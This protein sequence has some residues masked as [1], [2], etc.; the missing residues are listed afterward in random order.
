MTALTHRSKPRRTGSGGVAAR[1]AV[2]RWAWRMFRRE[3]RRQILVIALLTVAVAAAI[4]SVTIAYNAAAADDAEFGS[5]NHLIRFDGTDPRKLEAGLAAARDRFGT[6]DVIGHRSLDVPGSVDPVEF[7]SQAPR[8]PYGDARLALRRGSYPDRPG[9]VAV[10]DGVATLLGLEIG[11][12]LALDGRRRRVVGVVE[13]PRDLSDEFA[14]VTP[15]SARAPDEVTVLVE[16]SAGSVDAFARSLDGG[17]GSA[18]AG[19]EERPNDQAASALAMFSVATVFLLLASLV[20]S[21]GF[22]VIA[23]R[24]LRQLG[25]LTAIGATEKHLRLVLLTGGAVVG[26]IGAL[27]G[28]IVGLALWLAIVGTLEPAVGHRIDPLS[29]PWALLAATVLVAVLGATA[30]AWWPGRV[31]ARI[32]VTLALSARP[33]R[34]RPTHH[35]TV[36]AAVLIAAG[37]ASLALSGRDSEPLIVAGILA[38]ILGTLLLAPVAIRLFARAAGHAPLAARL[39]LR[40]LSRYQARSGAALA[41]ITLALGIA[42]A[43]VIV[44]EAEERKSASEPPNLSNRQIRVYAGG[45]AGPEVVPIRTPAELERMAGDVRRLAAGFDDAAVVPLHNAYQPGE[46]PVVHDGSRQ[47]LTEVLTRKIDDPDSARWSGRAMLCLGPAGCYVME[48]RLY[49]ATPAV[50]RYLGIDPATVDPSTDFLADRSTPTDELVIAVEQPGA[51]AAEAPQVTEVPVTN[52]QRIDSRKLFGSPEGESGL[53]R[54]SF[55]TLDGLRRLGWRQ[56]PSGWLVESSRPLTSEEISDSRELAADAGLAIETQ[57]ESTSLSELIAIAI[58]AGALLALGILAMTVGLIRGESAGDLRTLTAAG[59]TSTV[60]RTL[61]AT[62]AGALALLGAL[63]GVAGAY[64]ALVATYL[65]DLDYLGRIPALYLALLV[66]GVP[67]AA[68]AAGWLLS[69]REPPAI[70]R[71]AIE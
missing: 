39:A 65:D 32:P 16:A 2:V 54:T 50:L 17:S 4:G 5:A 70:A 26:A 57:R 6:T 27:I 7:R 51:G 45:T 35:S 1:R 40:D 36:L 10:T 22:A 68:I 60:R 47:R 58:A 25:A 41:A 31:V 8:G 52:V 13:N 63:L 9:Q 15:T 48:S 29:L 55:V 53:Q 20:A 61:T 11:E 44:A 23:Q 12:P 19:T 14:L 30:A 18:F 71:P 69:G 62:T 43:V 66:V 24:R 28:A 64:V 56:I 38:T 21:A 34:P 49:V 46:P 67:W 37:I 3:W 33:P 59:A 42:A